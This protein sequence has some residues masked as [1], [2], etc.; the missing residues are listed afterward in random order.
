MDK[1]TLKQLK[2]LNFKGLRD[3]TITFS[4]V[5][6]IFG[7]NGTGKTTIFDAFLWLMFGKDSA[8]RTDFNIKTLDTNN[9]A[10]HKMTHEVSA[11]IRVDED[12]VTIRRSYKEN[13]PTKKGTATETFSGHKQDFYW[14][15]VPLNETEFKKKIAAILDEGLFK[16]ITNTSYF[17]TLKWQDRRSVLEKLAGEITNA[18]VFDSILTPGNKDQFTSLI[19]AL[20]AKKS[21]YEYRSEISNKKKIIRD[22]KDLLP[23]RIDEAKRSLP[24]FVNYASIET[25][26][27]Q[28]KKDLEKVDTL[29]QNKTLALQDKQQVINGKLHQVQSL[30]TEARNIEF[31]EKNKV[32]DRKRE[33]EQVIMNL[34]HELR[35]K[36]DDATRKAIEISNDHSRKKSLQAQQQ[37]LRSKWAA[38][39]KEALEFKDNEFTCPACKRAYEATDIEAKKTQMISNFNQDKSRRLNMVTSEGKKV[40]A[41]VGAIDTIINDFKTRSELLQNEINDLK[42]K[43]ASAEQENTK[44]S[45]DDQSAFEKAMSG[46]QEHKKIIDQISLL[47]NEIN[48]PIAGGD[49]TELLSKKKEISLQIQGYQQEISLKGQREKIEA[50]I[51]ELQNQESEMAQELARLEGIEFSIMQ[52]EKSKMD[53]LET[54]VNSMFKIVKFKMFDTLINQGEVACCETLINGIPYSDANTASKIQAGVDIINTLCNFYNISAPIFI[55]N[56]ESVFLIP[57]SESQIIS[58]IASK[59]DKQLRIEQAA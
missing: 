21:L 29:I 50:R 25:K 16:L 3:T 7:D 45:S 10:F 49:N 9:K 44:F 52:F 26:L 14:N 20:N 46:N 38:I 34:K 19:N 59:P 39:D 15:D 23:S 18:M 56:R 33:R 53:M 41:E 13:W 31:A 27:D 2:L 17:V 5:T 24:D 42:Q 47:N 1:I 12:E 37:E 55:D 58:L 8:N 35:N 54:K 40:T 11:L 6:N 22:Q 28:S 48:K 4:N 43:I 32:Q 36:L 30:T 57:D 51:T